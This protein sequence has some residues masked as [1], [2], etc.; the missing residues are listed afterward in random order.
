MTGSKYETDLEREAII[1]RMARTLY[2][3]CLFD[4]LDC[5]KAY[6]SAAID[7]E[8]AKRFDAHA[9]EVERLRR[10]AF[11]E[12]KAASAAGFSNIEAAE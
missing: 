4:D 9:R 1:A 7:P 10:I 3:V 8:H 2:G 6:R 11:R 5:G 12:H